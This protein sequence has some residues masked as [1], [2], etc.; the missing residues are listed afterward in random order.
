MNFPYLDR[1]NL[2]VDE[3]NFQAKSEGKLTGFCI[4]N[5]RKI[6]SNGLFFTPV[7]RTS[8]MIAGSVIVYSEDEAIKIAQ[9]L[10]GNVD[11]VLVDSEKR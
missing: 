1:V 5:T 7:R 9:V 8:R 11:Y 3:V 10:D 6:D 4:G 2:I